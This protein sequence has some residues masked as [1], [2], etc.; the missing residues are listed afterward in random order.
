M[1]RE[2][3]L[4][5]VGEVGAVVGLGRGNAICAHVVRGD[6]YGVTVTD[7]YSMYIGSR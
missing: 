4:A 6:G 3:D 5:L 1:G 7:N 2:A